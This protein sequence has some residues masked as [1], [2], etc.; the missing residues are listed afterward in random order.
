[1]KNK[2]SHIVFLYIYFIKCIVGLEK[3][4]AAVAKRKGGGEI[5]QWIPTI[6]NHLYYSATSSGE[7]GDEKRAK[8]ANVLKHVTDDHSNCMHGELEP[9]AYIKRGESV[10]IKN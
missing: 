9:R 4:L 5:R 3:K 8:W 2:Y 1:M 7:N 10:V 6:R